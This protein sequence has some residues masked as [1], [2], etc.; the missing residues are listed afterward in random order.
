MKIDTHIHLYDPA[1]NLSWPQPGSALYRKV[2][3]ADFLEAAEKQGVT[4]AVV[5]ECAVEEENNLY[6]LETLKDEE[7]VLAYIA[8]IDSESPEFKRIYDEFAR[9]SKFRGLRY[10]FSSSKGCANEARNNIAYLSGKKANIVELHGRY[11][12]LSQL[13]GLISE[14]PDV[15]FVIDH[16][17]CIEI[18]GREVPENYTEFLKEMSSFD[19]VFMKL[20]AIICLSK[21]VPAPVSLDYYLPVLEANWK[22]FGEDRLIFGSD[23]PVLELKGEYRY[24]VELVEEFLRVK[25]SESIEKVMSQNAVGTYKLDNV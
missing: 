3:A 11:Y 10:R 12:E 17:G 6:M 25:S 20:S 1:Q 22:Y 24:A 23:W 15:R 18:N 16:L 4:R 5:V 8:Y 7:A 21:D 14:N 19:N 13:T 2:S 9:Y